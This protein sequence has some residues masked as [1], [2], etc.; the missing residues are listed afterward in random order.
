MTTLLRF[1]SYIALSLTILP[2]I[3]YLGGRM[4]LD[5]TKLFMLIAAVVW[6]ATTPFWM[7]KEKAS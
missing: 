6:F 4:T 7:D 1:V 3:L 2:S 5:A